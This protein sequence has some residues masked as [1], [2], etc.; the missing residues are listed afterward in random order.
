MGKITKQELSSALTTEIEGSLA[1][2]MTRGYQDISGNN[3]LMAE[4]DLGD[5]V[6]DEDYGLSVSIDGADYEDVVITIALDGTL[7]Q[8]VEDLNNALQ[9]LSPSAEA[10]LTSAG[11]IRVMSSSM[12][13]EST[14]EMEDD[15]YDEETGGGLVAR[16]EAVVQDEVAIQPPRVGTSTI[17]TLVGVE[18]ILNAI[19]EELHPTISSS[20]FE[21]VEVGEQLA[22]LLSYHGKE[23]ALV[24]VEDND[25][26]FL[27]HPYHPNTTLQN[28]ELAVL[29]PERTNQVYFQGESFVKVASDPDGEIGEWETAE[30]LAALINELEDWM[31]T[32]MAGNVSVY[33]A[34]PG[35]EWMN[36]SIALVADVVETDGADGET[37]PATAIITQAMIDQTILNDFI[38]FDGA[39]FWKSEE[40]NASL[41]AWADGEGLASCIDELGDWGASESGGNITITAVD[42]E[43]DKNGIPIIVT[44][45][46]VTSIDEPTNGHLVRED[47]KIALKSP[48]DIENFRAVRAD[49]EDAIIRVTY[50]E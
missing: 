38:E 45:D 14:I 31:A 24:T 6:G 13:I 43:E 40:T 20:D 30:D 7:G 15:T 8:V 32:H 47:Q 16:I 33:S 11:A 25:I 27:M 18:E 5:G 50:F 37:T 21:T 35:R 26:R 2:M 17:S 4:T 28:D 22:L 1:A 10:N 42:N 34:E 36:I 12:G 41:G 19:R 44:H 23:E 49:N 9:D 39:T 46:R 29:N 48:Q 3:P